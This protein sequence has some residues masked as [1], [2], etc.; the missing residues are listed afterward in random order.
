MGEECARK[1]LDALSENEKEKL[2]IINHQCFAA[3]AYGWRNISS[4]L[5]TYFCLASQRYGLYEGLRFFINLIREAVLDFGSVL[6]ECNALNEPLQV[7][8]M[9][10]RLLIKTG[11]VKQ[12]L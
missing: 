5:S 3:A 7:R 10:E 9:L 4:I 6:K 2:W 8:F 11:F 1:A 12:S